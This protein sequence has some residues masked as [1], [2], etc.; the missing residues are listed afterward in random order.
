ME[1][2]RGLPTMWSQREV[3]KQNHSGHAGATALPKATLL[4]P[5]Q[6]SPSPPRQ[7]NMLAA[8]GNTFP[9]GYYETKLSA[10]KNECVASNLSCIKK[11]V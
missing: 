7:H 11:P 4:M 2:A 10:F 8:M 3:K 1:N 5:V 9:G 6:L